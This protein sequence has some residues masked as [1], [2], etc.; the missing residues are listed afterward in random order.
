MAEETKVEIP[1]KFKDLVEQVEKLPGGL[2]KK[3]KLSSTISANNYVLF[4]KFGKIKKYEDEVQILEDFFTERFDLYQKR[5]D[6][7]I[8]VLKKEVA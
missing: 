6:Y 3:F 4:D 5:K 7:L 1:A 2:K 8:R